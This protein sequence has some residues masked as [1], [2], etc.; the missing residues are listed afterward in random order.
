MTVRSRL[1]AAELAPAERLLIF[2]VRAWLEADE[3]AEGDRMAV[4]QAIG[5]HSSARTAAVFCAWMETVEMC[6]LRPL[7]A[8]CAH[9]GGVGQDVQRL[10]V[11]CGLATV[12][13]DLGARLIEPLVCETETV[14]TLARSLNAALAACGSPLPARFG[15][16]EVA[17]QPHP[18][19]H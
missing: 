1:P 10:V 15:S 3:D 12:D 11:A 13:V 5:R 14:M 2:G 7:S 6:R 4:A 19:L 16:P 18:R 8:E 17:P 9:C